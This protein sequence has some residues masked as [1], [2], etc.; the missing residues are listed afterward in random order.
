[1]KT[2]ILNNAHIL[3]QNNMAANV[4][5]LPGMTQQGV[6]RAAGFYPVMAPLSSPCLTL[7]AKTTQQLF[8]YHTRLL[9]LLLDLAT[10]LESVTQE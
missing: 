6:Y 10:V 5:I 1:M 4:L 8:P 7:P 9:G 3:G 2:Q